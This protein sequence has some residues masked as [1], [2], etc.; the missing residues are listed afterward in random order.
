[1]ADGRMILDHIGVAANSIEESIGLY[2]DLLGLDLG[3]IEEIADQ[4]VKAAFL[5]VGDTNIEI[6]EPTSPD[7]P[8]AGFLEKKGGGIH[9]IAIRVVGIEAMIDKLKAAGVRMIDEKPRIGAHN[10]KI[11]FIHPK[12]TNGVLIEICE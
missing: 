1:M 6:I 5:K 4:K 12:S 10:K 8:I 7:S 9:H 2:R 11:A 3:G